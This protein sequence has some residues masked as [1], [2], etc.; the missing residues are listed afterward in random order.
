MHFFENNDIYLQSELLLQSRNKQTCL[1]QLINIRKILLKGKKN[2]FQIREILVKLFLLKSVSD[3]IHT[4]W[5]ANWVQILVAGTL[6][7]DINNLVHSLS[8]VDAFVT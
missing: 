3:W 6:C 8:T 5:G 7:I 1:K 4:L 2:I